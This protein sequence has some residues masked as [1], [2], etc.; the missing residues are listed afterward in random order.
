MQKF[1]FWEWTVQY[2]CISYGFQLYIANNPGF[3]SQL[4]IRSMEV[5]DH[6]WNAQ[7]KKPCLTIKLKK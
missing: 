4:I 5:R 1:C 2:V 7:E 3:K 6:K